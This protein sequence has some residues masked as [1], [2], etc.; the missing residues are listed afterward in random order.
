MLR[1]SST[2]ET[3]WLSSNWRRPRRYHTTFVCPSV[4]TTDSSD[5]TVSLG[6]LTNPKV[7]SLGPASSYFQY[8]KRVF[9]NLNIL[10]LRNAAL[11]RSA[12]FTQTT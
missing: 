4:D 1:G 3:S 7:N 5:V 11:I 8:N 12:I 6:L 2:T 10:A 9:E